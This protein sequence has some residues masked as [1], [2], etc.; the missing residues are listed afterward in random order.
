MRRRKKYNKLSD[1]KRIVQLNKG[2]I[3]QEFKVGEFPDLPPLS[4]RNDYFSNNKKKIERLLR[5]FKRWP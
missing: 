5:A 2:N 4:K 1:S 3:T